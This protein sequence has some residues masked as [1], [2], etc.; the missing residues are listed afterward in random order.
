[1]FSLWNKNKYISWKL[2]IVLYNFYIYIYI[3][4]NNE[5]NLLE[6]ETERSFFMAVENEKRNERTNKK[7]WY[8]FRWMLLL[9]LLASVVEKKI[10]FSRAP[11]SIIFPSQMKWKRGKNWGKFMKENAAMKF[12]SHTLWTTFCFYPGVGIWLIFSGLLWYFPFYAGD[13]IWKAP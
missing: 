2:Y 13:I 9:L 8:N 11:L 3:I 5:N 6:Q 12:F 10:F 7:N 1:M 4:N